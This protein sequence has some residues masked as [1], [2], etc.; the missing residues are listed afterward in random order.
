MLF[1][2]RLARLTLG[3]AL[4]IRH[5]LYVH[6]QAIAGKVDMDKAYYVILD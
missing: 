2:L 6:L 5:P 4:L 1:W 3:A